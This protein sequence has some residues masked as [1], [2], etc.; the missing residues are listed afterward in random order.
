DVA[1]AIGPLAAINDAVM[2]GGISSK[3][4]I[5]LWVMAVGAMG[6]AIG[7]ALYGPKLI[8]TVGS[9]ITELD[10]MRAFSVAMAA[11]ITVIIASQLG[12]PV[13]S[14][15]I[16]V[17]GIF[18]V[19]FLREYLEGSKQVDVIALEKEAIIDEKKL[20]KA[21]NSELK[22]LESKEEKVK[23]DYERIVELYKMVDEEE[24][25][26]KEAK[27]Q[28][29]STQKVQY[30]KRDAVKKIIAAWVITVPAAAVLSAAIYFMIKGI[31]L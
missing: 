26:I 24:A 19:G 14:T 25:K 28:L 29:K 30:V 12:L 11:S 15:H 18:G 17:G 2:T 9:E 23:N 8:K 10:Q 31:V 3:A 7:L 4:G 13:S 1:N 21:L 22:K 16:A 20:L 5:P 27:K 6:I